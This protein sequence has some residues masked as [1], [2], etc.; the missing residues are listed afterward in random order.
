MQAAWIRK[1]QADTSVVFVHGI[2]SSGEACWRHTNGSYWPELLKG[3]EGF[4]SLGIYVFTYRTGVFSGSYRLSDI[5]D[6]LKEQMRLDGVLESRQL[7]F[8]CHS[9][10]GIVVRKFLVERAAELIE[11]KREIGLFLVASPSLG[12]SYADWLSPLAQLFG[13]SQADVLRFARGNDW[14]KDLDKEFKNLKEAGRLKIKGKELVEDKFV[15]VSKLLGKQVVEPLSGAVY[16]GEPFRVPESDHFS[17][18]KPPNNAAI[19]HR[20]LCRFINDTLES[21]RDA[22]MKPRH[23]VGLHVSVISREQTGWEKPPL[24]RLSYAIEQSERSLRIE[25]SLGYLSL[26]ESG[27]AIEPLKFIWEPFQWDF[28]NIDVKLVNNGSDTVFVTEAVF[29]ISE[30]RVDPFPVLRLTVRLGD[31]GFGLFNEGWGDVHDLVARFSLS[32]LERFSLSPLDGRVGGASPAGAF[33]HQAIVGDFSEQATVDLTRAFLD[34]GV[35]LGE[36]GKI[37]WSDPE[38]ALKAFR[39]LLGPFSARGRVAEDTFADG[40]AIV[41]GELRFRAASLD[42]HMRDWRVGFTTRIAL[43]SIQMGQQQGAP[44]PPTY[45]YGT[46]FD[47]EPD[48]YERHVPVSHVLKPGEADRFAIKIGMEQSGRYRFRMRALFNDG[49][50]VDSPEIEMTTFIPRSG[51]Q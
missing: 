44:A 2:L 37:D 33:P 51:R 49:Q 40:G 30:S 5:V 7:I 46:R 9:M 27:G 35:D 36:V 21:P 45:Q 48:P 38:K 22:A 31:H 20:L 47:V 41:S 13:H 34:L 15:I 17:I 26:L 32:P 19:Q 50:S 4:S 8:V 18:A 39:A 42:H 16:F 14:L 29:D 1:P 24:T 43:G 11:G 3:E 23:S 6:A 10:G 25:R 12:S 28:P